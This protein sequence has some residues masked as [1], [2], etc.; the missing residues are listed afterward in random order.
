MFLVDEYRCSFLERI[1]FYNVEGRGHNSL[2]VSSGEIR[3][4]LIQKFHIWNPLSNDL[5]KILPKYAIEMCQIMKIGQIVVLCDLSDIWLTVPTRRPSPSCNECLNLVSVC[6]KWCRRNHQAYFKLTFG[7]L[8]NKTIMY[9]WF[10]WC[11]SDLRLVNDWLNARR[12]LH[13]SLIP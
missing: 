11:I 5:K 9:K 7:P 10:K 3:T 4:S 8:C 2:T 13:A 1:F 6:S 12:S